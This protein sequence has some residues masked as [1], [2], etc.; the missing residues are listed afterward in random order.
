MNLIS[1]L[2]SVVSSTI[3]IGR[4][5]LAYIVAVPSPFLMEFYGYDESRWAGHPLFTS[6]ILSFF[7]FFRTTFSLVLV[8]LADMDSQYLCHVLVLFSLLVFHKHWRFPGV[9]SLAHFPLSPSLLDN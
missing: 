8:L 6:S 7:G 3:K 9:L 4:N 5:V 2:E 1:V